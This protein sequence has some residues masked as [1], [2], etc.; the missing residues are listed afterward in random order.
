MGR[1]LNNWITATVPYER[2][3]P[4]AVGW[5]STLIDHDDRKACSSQPISTARPSRLKAGWNP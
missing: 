2:R 1:K 3:W 5:R 4:G